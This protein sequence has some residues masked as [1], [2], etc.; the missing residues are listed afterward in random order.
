MQ[1]A[2]KHLIK[3]QLHFSCEEAESN[4]QILINAFDLEHKVIFW[5]KRAEI[6]FG[7]SKEAAIGKRLEDLI[8]YVNKSEKMHLLDRALQGTPIH[9]VKDWYQI[10]R[11][12]YEQWVL[13]VKKDGKTVAALNIVKTLSN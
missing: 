5:N 4:T 8:P 10:I 2:L 12:A 9:V 6:Y 11:A 13:P 1:N 3:D 7:V